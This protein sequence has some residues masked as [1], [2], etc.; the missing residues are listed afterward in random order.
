ML[1][2]VLRFGM[3]IVAIAS[4]LVAYLLYDGRLGVETRL[5]WDGGSTDGSPAASQAP[6]TLAAVT[7]LPV[8]ITT[9]QSGDE[10][11]G[12][13]AAAPDQDA[14]TTVARTDPQSTP[15]EDETPGDAPA[16]GLGTGIGA[17]MFGSVPEDTGTQGTG[18]S[19]AETAKDDGA[20][21]EAR[22]PVDAPVFDVV[23]VTED[24]SA[25][26][27]GRGRP[28]ERVD[29]LRDG[30]PIAEAVV[31]AQGN[32]AIFAEIGR[33]EGPLSLQLRS[34]RKPEGDAP[35]RLATLDVL[36]PGSNQSVPRPLEDAPAVSDADDQVASAVDA[37]ATSEPEGVLSEPILLLPSQT[38]GEG[39]RVVASTEEGVSVSGPDM[40][41]VAT[42]VLDTVSYEEGGDA[43]ARGRS[44]A[45]ATVRVF[46]N[47]APV[48]ETEAGEDGS[49]EA[50]LPR[51]AAAEAQLLRFEEVMPDGEVRRRLET[52]F[53]YAPGDGPLL[54][55][56][57]TIVVAQGDSLWRIAENLYG[58]GLRY[59]VIF[60]ANDNLIVDPD[61]IYPE[62]VFVVPNLVPG[63]AAAGSS[64]EPAER[65]VRQ[66]Q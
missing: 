58:E 53:D 40:A 48:A 6:D 35:G 66:I 54:L 61:L 36:E 51:S 57:R 7:Q 62:Q 18:D 55:Q 28:G 16:G 15:T 22:D 11:D 31:D 47:N 49:W 45:G 10:S 5:T 29:L 27:A 9:V 20:T 39:P 33:V 50:T 38:G 24:G 43:V 32:F 14:L 41:P 26:I 25:V 4:A 52:R 37:L 44:P 42:L 3:S 64:P 46:V 34:D 60:G 65:P 21:S 59:S 2:P 1:K 13:D 19:G 17:T 56:E 8:E 30:E 12:H 63:A 23:R